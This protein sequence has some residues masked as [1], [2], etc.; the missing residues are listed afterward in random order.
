[1][2]LRTVPTDR[3]DLDVPCAATRDASGNPFLIWAEAK[4][5]DVPVPHDR[6]AA[7]RWLREHAA[8]LGHTGFTAV[9]A[10]AGTF[11]G[12]DEWKFELERD[13]LRLFD[14]DVS[15]Y[16]DADGRCLGL[17]NRV[18]RLGSVVAKPAEGAGTEVWYA[19]R[20]DRGEV[21]RAR[22]V[23][24]TTETHRVT[25]LF[26]T[27]RSVHRILEQLHWPAQA[28][29]ATITEYTSPGMVFPDQI[30]ADSKGLIWFSEPPAARISVF[31]PNTGN[32]SSHPT[33]GWSSPD[34]LVVDD[35]DRVWFGLYST[36]HGLGTI[37]IPSGRFT[38]YPAPY[39][40]A[41]LAIP[42]PSGRGTIYVTDHFSER[43]SEFDPETGTWVRSITLPSP[44]YPVGAHLEAET[45]DA[46]FPLYFFH[47]LGRLTPAGQFTR[48]QAPSSGGPAFGAANDGRVYFTYWLVNRIGVYD[49]AAGTF[50]EYVMR[51]G[52]VGGP[53]AMSP[54]GEAVIGTRNVGYIAVFDP[55]TRTFTD[56]RIPT[57]GSGLKD[58]LTV[59]P[60]GTVWFTE[61]GSN[62]IAKLVLP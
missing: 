44:S 38:R 7:E 51:A 31:D 12:Y 61:S 25:E 24:S 1:M 52:E 34:G 4:D 47:G 56:Y 20:D 40:G 49:I 18:P 42:T 54:T 17:S 48:L 6:A 2:G 55:V 39:P 22:L 46:W 29:Q 8:A 10:R 11:R 9:F 43:I 45:Q 36:D 59:A 62:K 41:N 19:R 26:D 16:F 23:T 5:A 35:Q 50:T 3:V 14:A 60:D 32:F 15:L 30:W 28:E 57:G 27:G 37:D 21:V 58:G 53:M 13:G 33:T